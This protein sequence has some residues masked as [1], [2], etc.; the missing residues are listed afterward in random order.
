MHEAQN[1]DCA[2]FSTITDD[3]FRHSMPTVNGAH[4]VK[5]VT[6]LTTGNCQLPSSSNWNCHTNN[7]S[8]ANERSMTFHEWS[9]V[10]PELNYVNY[11][12][13]QQNAQ[14]TSYSD[15]GQRLCVMPHVHAGFRISS[16]RR[17][18]SSNMEYE[19]SQA[20]KHDSCQ[21]SN[22]NCWR[23]QLTS[24]CN[25][26]SIKGNLAF[27]NAF[28]SGIMVG[29]TSS[30]TAGS[31][32]SSLPVTTATMAHP[33]NSLG[34]SSVAFDGLQSLQDPPCRHAA[35]FNSGFTE[36]Q[37]LSS[38]QQPIH[39]LLQKQFLENL[40]QLQRSLLL[41]RNSLATGPLYHG[42]QPP[43]PVSGGSNQCLLTD[44]GRISHWSSG[45]AVANVQN[46]PSG[47]RFLRYIYIYTLYM[48]IFF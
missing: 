42:Y 12:S 16:E 15:A 48:Y 36:C 38:Q 22:T 26:E 9:S 41:P 19:R 25:S 27:W 8:E 43:V 47:S 45:T 4:D 44:V 23:P 18:N 7:V 29:G 3:S 1:A 13:Y 2:G 31:S 5:S 33:V 20:S 6:D 40:L 14:V 35:S 10:L 34:G 30:C 39:Y 37:L 46:S 24:V 11:S 32:R 21:L 17:Q 28:T